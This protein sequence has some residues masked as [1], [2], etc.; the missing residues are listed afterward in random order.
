MQPK[1]GVLAAGP[2]SGAPTQRQP[3]AA[4][5]PTPTAASSVGTTPNRGRSTPSRA[6]AAASPAAAPRAACSPTP[7]KRR[8]ASP[9]SSSRRPK[10]TTYPAAGTDVRVPPP[11]PARAASPRKFHVVA[12]TDA[13]APPLAG[14]ANRAPSAGVESRVAQRG[15][16]P[17]LRLQRHAKAAS[18]A[19]RKSVPQATPPARQAPAPQPQEEQQ[20]QEQP[21][22]SPHEA[23]EAKAQAALAVSPHIKSMVDRAYSMSPPQQQQRRG[24]VSPR[25]AAETGVSGVGLLRAHQVKVAVDGGKREELERQR[26]HDERAAAAAAAAAAA[27]ASASAA[28]ASAAAFIETP[29]SLT[30]DVV[31][32]KLAD[33]WDSLDGGVGGRP[34]PGPSAAPG[35]MRGPISPALPAAVASP[36]PAAQSPAGEPG[37]AGRCPG[38]RPAWGVSVC[39]RCRLPP[40]A[41]DNERPGTG[42]RGGGDSVFRPTSQS[43]PPN[44]ALPPTPQ[45]HA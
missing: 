2:R 6:L 7:Q 14:Q 29:P 8:V 35:G 36:Q 22:A 13:P 23:A 28:A 33:I 31:L 15:R 41:H 45:P 37:S 30:Q 39:S 27:S 24:L 1:K 38:F 11:E 18:P 20:E 17:S 9:V 16:Q 4:T 43:P 19:A 42:L 34:G 44:P 40:A 25:V 10:T 21:H 26:Q 5:L 3:A 32:R 12:P